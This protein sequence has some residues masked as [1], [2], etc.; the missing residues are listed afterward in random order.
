MGSGSC[1]LKTGRAGVVLALVS[2]SSHPAPRDHRVAGD[3]G[4]PLSEDESNGH[5]QRWARWLDG[6]D[7]ESHLVL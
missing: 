4:G 2:D 3:S 7:Q 5:G 1:S 6:A